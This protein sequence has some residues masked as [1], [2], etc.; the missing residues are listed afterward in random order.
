MNCNH[1]EEL[2]PLYVEGDLSAAETQ[3]V[4]SHLQGCAGCARLSEEYGESQEW[5]QSYTAPAFDGAFYTGLRQ[6]IMREI[7]ARQRQPL[8]GRP[9]FFE[10]FRQSWFVKPAFVAAALLIVFGAAMFVLYLNRDE[11]NIEQQA[12][13]DRPGQIDKDSKSAD[14]N[15]QVQPRVPESQGPKLIAEETSNQKRRLVRRNV[16]KPVE[17]AYPVMIAEPA[18]EPA[19]IALEGIEENSEEPNLPEGDKARAD[20]LRI[21]FQTSDPN[22]RIIWFTPKP[23]EPSERKIDTE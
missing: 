6:N 9:L 16:R 7:D 8:L 13:T 14:H 5:L 1:V 15:S 20:M 2:M 19:V 17:E 23:T 12:G 18:R 10:W 11:K 4:A 3:A 21:E 22:I